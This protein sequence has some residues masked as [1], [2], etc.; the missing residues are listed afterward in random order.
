MTSIVEK[1]HEYQIMTTGPFGWVLGQDENSRGDR[2]VRCD[3]YGLYL[4]T[5]GAAKWKLLT[6]ASRRP[7][8]SNPP[9]HG[10]GGCYAAVFAPSNPDIIYTY[11]CRKL[12]R[13][14]DFG[15]NFSELVAPGLA[16]QNPNAQNPG[17]SRF[18]SGKMAVDPVNPDVA[19]LAAMG[20]AL[21]RCTDG[22]NFA[23]HAGLPAP[24]HCAAK[25]CRQC[26]H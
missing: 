11:D 12:L 1:P 8:T 9:H 13:S 25:H 6:T 19:Y 23:A 7:A 3:T 24:D 4:L 14:N 20:L 10:G 16:F 5:F 2:L 17:Q 26:S 18:T 15:E 21:W 22:L